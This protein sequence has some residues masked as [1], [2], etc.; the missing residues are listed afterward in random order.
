MQKNQSLAERV[1]RIA[2]KI[3]KF[4]LITILVL[5]ILSVLTIFSVDRWVAWRGGTAIV[6]ADEV[7]PPYDAIIVLGAQVVDNYYPSDMLRDRLDG[8]VE[9]YKAGVS[10]RILVTGDHR[11]DNYNEVAVMT[12]YLLEHDVP[13]QAIF[14][15]HYGLDTYDSIYRSHHV[16]KIEKAIIVTQTFHLQRA[17]YV[18][19]SLD[20]DYQ[21]YA[22]DARNYKSSTYTFLREYGARL[23]AVYEVRSQ[24]SPTR[25]DPDMPISGDGRDSREPWGEAWSAPE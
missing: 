6:E 14:M 11:E 21:G 9:L 2:G 19:R 5:I 20:L 24:A 1:I 25:M 4:V 18:A 8:A 3:I 23:K 17:L 15:D 13:D 7:D 16:F 12:R 22:T 10:D